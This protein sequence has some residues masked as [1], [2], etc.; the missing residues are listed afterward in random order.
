[1]S[2]RPVD[3]SEVT[4]WAGE[5]DVVVVGFG[6]AGACAAY[7]AATTG[8]SV[9]IL[10]RAGGPGGAS[11]LS[12]GM[13]YLGGGTGTQAAAG[14]TDSPEA[15]RAFL[16]AACGPAPDE[17]KI[18]L[19]VGRSV[20]HHDWLLARGVRFLG[21][22]DPLSA[23]PSAARGEGLMFTGGENAW[24]FDELAAPAQR[25]HVTQGTRQ[26]GAA[27]M[28]ALGAE[29]ERA[30]AEP[31]YGVRAERLITEDG[32]VRGVLA[33]RYG[34]RVAF[35]AAGGVVLASGGFVFN[36]EMLSS[37]APAALR[38]RTRLGTE[39]DDGQGIRMA[40]AVGARVKR[41]DSL[42]WALPF[43]MARGNVSGILVNALGRR[44]VN[45]D[46]YMG[47]VG[48]AAMHEE[49]V[50]LI[51][52]E[53]RYD[54]AALGTPASAVAESADELGAELGLPAGSLT[55]TLAYY[56]EHAA[57]GEDPL[58]RKRPRWLTPLTGPLAAFALGPRHFPH[59]VFTLGGLDTLPTGEV[60]DQDGDPVPGLYAAGRTTS[61]VAA[62]GYCSGLSLGDGSLFGR[63]AGRR[64]TGK[65]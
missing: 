34:Q 46:T 38:T 23:G 11:A 65:G 26:G 33:D 3:A 54:P 31:V 42:E 6:V 17:S 14:V 7:E 56:N 53:A 51:V 47:R 27:L 4:E 8:A 15:M 2:V 29:A 10:E 50:H 20:E 40:Q 12:D 45:E 44:F 59:C 49:A 39:G 60:L 18:D 61:G 5:A 48:Q 30:G 55:A 19:Y 22:V 25:A 13:I 16:L 62:R 32:R 21:T 63:L 24:P 28:A 9:L 36:D 35:R 37:Y 52:D 43:N 58:F 1:M 57:Q 64:A 41:M